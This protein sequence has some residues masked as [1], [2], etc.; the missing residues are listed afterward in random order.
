[1]AVATAWWT[2]AISQ[3]KGEG[4]GADRSSLVLRQAG[5]AFPARHVCVAGDNAT[6][7]TYLGDRGDERGSYDGF[8]DITGSKLSSGVEVSSV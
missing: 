3:P 2:R 7:G 4:F 1:M 5:G 8:V 6:I